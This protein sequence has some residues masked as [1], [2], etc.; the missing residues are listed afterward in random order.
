VAHIGKETNAES[1]LMLKIEERNH[2]EVLV[3]D[4]RIILKSTLKNMLGVEDCIYLPQN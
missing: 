3:I 1:V 2:L 4:G